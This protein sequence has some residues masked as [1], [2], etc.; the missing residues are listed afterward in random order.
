MKRNKKEAGHESEGEALKDVDLENSLECKICVTTYKMFF[1][2][3]GEDYFHRCK[4]VVPAVKPGEDQ[5]ERSRNFRG[6]LNKW[7]SQHVTSHDREACDIWLSGP[8]TEP[9]AEGAVAAAAAAA[10]AT[11]AGYA[12]TAAP[13]EDAPPAAAPDPAAAVAPAEDAA[14]DAGVDAAGGMDTAADN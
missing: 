11:A 6:F 3:K 9:A 13:V 10:A 2:A 14:A 5:S 7:T 4:T 12:A 8:P 1:V